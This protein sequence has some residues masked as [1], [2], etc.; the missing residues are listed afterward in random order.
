VDQL[1]AG[2][3]A[4]Y[5][6]SLAMSPALTRGETERLLVELEMLM[7]ERQRTT[8]TLA[9]LVSSFAEVRAALN[10]LHGTIRP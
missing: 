8:A 10:E 9:R 7:I 5:R 1:T 4:G 6:R 2:D 3:I